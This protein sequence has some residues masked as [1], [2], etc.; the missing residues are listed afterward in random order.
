MKALSEKLSLERYKKKD[1]KVCNTFWQEEAKQI[2][3]KFGIEGKWR[4]MIF[5]KAKQSLPNLKS[6]VSYCEERGIFNGRYLIAMY[7]KPMQKES[8]E[9]IL[10]QIR[11]AYRDGQYYKVKKL[12]R[13]HGWL[14]TKE[15]YNDILIAVENIKPSKL[16]EEAQEIMGE[17]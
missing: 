3:E 17:K 7:R 16:L 12:L 1:K 4:T 11:A 6:K 14:L 2:C 9:R 10:E 13:T 5:Q 15:K 8:N